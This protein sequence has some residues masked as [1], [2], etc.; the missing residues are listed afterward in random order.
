MKPYSLG[1]KLKLARRS[2]NL[3]LRNVEKA[4]GIS[5]AYLSQ[6]ETNKI[7]KPS[8]HFL[9]RLASIYEISYDSLMESAGYMVGGKIVQ[10]KT[11]AIFDKMNLSAE[12]EELIAEYLVFLRR[13][14]K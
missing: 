11:P 13:K 5:N 12:E 7:K 8:P 14:S 3:S 10:P 1:T 9:H 6:L 4:T 2:L